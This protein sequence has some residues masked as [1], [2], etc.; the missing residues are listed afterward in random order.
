MDTVGK[1]SGPDAIQFDF[2]N[3][4][5]LLDLSWQTVPV[6]ANRQHLQ[7][8][9]VQSILLHMQRACLNAIFLMRTNECTV[10]SF[11]RARPKTIVWWDM[12]HFLLYWRLSGNKR[13]GKFFICEY[14]EVLCV[15]QCMPFRSRVG[16]ILIELG[17]FATS[18]SHMK[19]ILD[20]GIFH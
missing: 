1:M 2:T 12:G 5:W 14:P 16:W 7:L 15:W 19:A 4:T 11:F 3:R 17:L 6:G 8:L 9:V 10:R 18:Y 20:P 13:I